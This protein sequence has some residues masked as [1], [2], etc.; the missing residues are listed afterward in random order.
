[1]DGWM[2]K[3]ADGWRDSSS[4]FSFRLQSWMGADGKVFVETSSARFR[5]VW[6][7]RVC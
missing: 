5:G 2:N 4:I 7:K 6:G 1:M 3:E